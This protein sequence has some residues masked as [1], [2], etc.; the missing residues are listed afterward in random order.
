MVMGL[1]AA[2][3]DPDGDGEFPE[4]NELEG[5]PGMDIMSD[6]GGKLTVDGDELEKNDTNILNAQEFQHMMDASR[7]S[8][9]DF[10][11]NV[12]QRM[13]DRKTDTLTVYTNVD[14]AMGEEFDE[15]YAALASRLSA[16]GATDDFTR[17]VNDDPAET[18]YGTLTFA[19]S[20]DDEGKGYK[21]MMGS[22]IPTGAGQNREIDPDD[23]F[24]GTFRGIP[25]TYACSADGPCTL[26]TNDD[27]ELRIEGALMFT[28]RKTVNDTDDKHMISGVH[29]DENYLVFGYWLQEGT[30]RAGDATYAVNAFYGGSEPIDGT[31]Y[32]NLSNL[33]GQATYNGEASGMYAK[34]AL[35]VGDGGAV[36][37]TPSEAGQF[38]ASASLTANFG[39][40]PKVATGEI[41]MITGTISNFLDDSGTAID[42]NWSLALNGD[43]GN[44]VSGGDEFGTFSGDTGSGSNKGMWEGQFFGIPRGTDGTTALTGNMDYPTSAAGKFT[45]HFENGHVIGA[46]GATKKK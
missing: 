13:K 37:G 30:D 45:G 25:G 41:F 12:Y 14:E 11:V 40:N 10:D 35:S 17:G 18:I 27:N 1:T 9:R 24:T 3:A 16:D 39:A 6:D 8:L 5:R 38:T 44:I 34:K 4:A 29:P 23:D 42:G 21:H 28:P 26:T 43:T 32:A 19:A 15:Y 46:F 33:V 2:I 20:G 36:V 7:A 31:S 22:K